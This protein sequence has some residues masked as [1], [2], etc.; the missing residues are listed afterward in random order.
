[1]SVKNV[2]NMA[3][4][5][6]DRLLTLAKANG[7]DEDVAVEC[8]P[9]ENRADRASGIAMGD[10]SADTSVLCARAGDRYFGRKDVE[11]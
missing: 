5:V 11:S 4:S 9:A 6:R 7:R 3:H 10:D 8:F 2:T 1:M